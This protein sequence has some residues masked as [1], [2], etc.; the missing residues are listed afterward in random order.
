[1]LL[2]NMKDVGCHK[3]RCDTD[4]HDFYGFHAMSKCKLSRVSPKHRYNI[5]KDEEK[6]NTIM[7]QQWLLGEYF[8]Q[9][10]KNTP[11][12]KQ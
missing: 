8:R 6:T 3:L 1:M 10:I 4:K 2:G 11:L 5:I 9:S 7:Q 12:G